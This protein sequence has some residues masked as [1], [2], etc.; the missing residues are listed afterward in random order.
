MAVTTL[1]EVTEAE[2]Q[3]KIKTV[4][5][6]MKSTFRSPV[7]SPAFRL[8]ATQPDYLEIAWRC[9][10]AN[11]QT[12]YFEN[13][14]D[15][16]RA[17]AVEGTARLDQAPWRSK[18]EDV[19]GVLRVFHYL[20]P[21]A[22]L[23]VAALQSATAGQHPKLMEIR[24]DDK[25]QIK[26]GIPE[27][28]ADVR[29]VDLSQL[30]ERARQIL[31]DVT[32]T[33]RI[34]GASSE[35]AALAPW[36]DYLES[37]WGAWKPLTTQPDHRRVERELRRLAE[38]AIA[39]LPFRMDVSAHALRHAGLSELQLDQVQSLLTTLCAI[40][41]GMTMAFAFFM[42]GAEGKPAAM[43]SPFPAEPM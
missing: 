10:K 20:E 3:G 39:G 22:F 35:L 32:R 12:M 13:R 19:R 6:D 7:V 38:G 24:A 33:L 17:R 27:G 11:V 43:R 1:K 26:P 9:L 16:L 40:M 21:K 37:A 42:A 29:T 25:R 18:A 34:P 14:A 30:D 41:P 15:A 8:L 23:A 2:A 36:P 5:E 31:D 28:A 4:Y